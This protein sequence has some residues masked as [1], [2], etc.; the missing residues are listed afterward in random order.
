MLLGVISD[1]HDNLPMIRKAVEILNEKNVTLVL[2]AGDIVSP[3]VA[4]EFADLKAPMIITL[5]NND[6]EHEVLRKR[7]ADVGKDVK[8]LFAEV[9]IGR[10]R[11]ALTHGDEKDLVPSLIRSQYYHVVVYGYTHEAKTY[12]SG[13]TLII[14]P[15]EICGY[16]SGVST[17]ALLDAE[18]R[19]TKI[20]QL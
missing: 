15:G 16:L 14:N 4:R 1:T 11:V 19:T 9:E 3:F 12:V 13:N 20:V 2:H 17:M 7:F 10:I 8:G 18:N 5:G 6:A